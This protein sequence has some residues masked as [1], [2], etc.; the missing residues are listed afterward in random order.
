MLSTWIAEIRDIVPG[1]RGGN[2]I[3]GTEGGDVIHTDDTWIGEIRDIVPGY[4]GGNVI[5]G[6][7]GEC[8]PHGRHMDSGNKARMNITEMGKNSEQTER[9]QT[10]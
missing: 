5:Q 1:Y 7:E 4:R 10:E 9:Q 3:Q 2:V 6:T 8:Y